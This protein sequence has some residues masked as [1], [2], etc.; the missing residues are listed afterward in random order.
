LSRIFFGIESRFWPAA[1]AAVHVG[2]VPGAVVGTS[3]A[4]LDYL[5]DEGVATPPNRLEMIMALELE[6]ETFG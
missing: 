1:L 2:P 4:A 6:L 5:K 3:D